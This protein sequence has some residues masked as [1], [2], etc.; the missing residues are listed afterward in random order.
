V[1]ASIAEIGMHNRR[2]AKQ[3]LCWIEASLEKAIHHRRI[4]SQR[5]LQ[6]L[7]RQLRPR[8]GVHSHTELLIVER[9]VRVRGLH[10]ADRTCVIVIDKRQEEVVKR[11]YV[12]NPLI[13]KGVISLRR[14]HYY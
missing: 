14:I 12:P 5:F 13:P 4:R 2:R 8:R 1:H 3:I 11:I 9:P 7:Y 6:D 10:A